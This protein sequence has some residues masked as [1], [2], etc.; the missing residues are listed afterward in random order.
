MSKVGVPAAGVT[1]DVSAT[2]KLRPRVVHAAGDGGDLGERA[3]GL[4]LR[5]GDLLQEDGH[6][7]AAASGR[8]EAVLDGDVVVREDGLDLDL[9]VLGQLGGQLEVHARRRCSS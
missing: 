8:A 7:D 1:H 4:G 5:A 6:T 9:L 3:A 2:P